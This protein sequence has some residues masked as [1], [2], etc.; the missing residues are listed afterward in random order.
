M[1]IRKKQ[2]IK[3]YMVLQPSNATRKDT[4]GN[5]IIVQPQ[6]E[7]SIHNQILV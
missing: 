4:Q 7:L 6:Q 1:K 2:H 5:L 3:C